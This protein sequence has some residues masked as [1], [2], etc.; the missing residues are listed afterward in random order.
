MEPQKMWLRLPFESRDPRWA[1]APTPHL[2]PVPLSPF[3]R[4][5]TGAARGTVGGAC[6]IGLKLYDMRHDLP[7]SLDKPTLKLYDKY[8]VTIQ[9]KNNEVLLAGAMSIFC[10]ILLHNI[11]LNSWSTSKLHCVVLFIFLHQL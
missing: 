1:P 3:G 5:P 8:N 4:A 9:R 10:T 2:E 7:I 11:S 6:Q